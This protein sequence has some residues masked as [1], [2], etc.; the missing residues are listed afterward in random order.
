MWYSIFYELVGEP[1][2]EETGKV[3]A[4]VLHLGPVSTPTTPLT[5]TPSQTNATRFRRSSCRSPS[6]LSCTP[7]ML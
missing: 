1:T 5:T 4:E 3:L 2:V 7:S 6:E